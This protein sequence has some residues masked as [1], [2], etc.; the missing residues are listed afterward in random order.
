MA[1]PVSLQDRRTP[2]WFYDFLNT[3][4]GPFVLDAAATKANALCEKFLSEAHDALN[5]AW[6]PHTFCNPPFKNMGLWVDK[7]RKEALKG[8]CVV[9]LAP[10]GGAQAWYHKI[11]RHYTILQPNMRISYDTPEGLPTGVD[12]C[13]NGLPNAECR[14][15]CRCINGADRDTSILL[16]GPGFENPNYASGQFQ[17]LSLNIRPAF[18]RWQAEYRAARDDV[19]HPDAPRLRVVS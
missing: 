5:V 7:A 17:I 13:H 14:K 2:Q 8:H 3:H 19:P 4:F 12:K 10:Q 11:A 18:K 6:A 1:K 16:F 15:E 9:I